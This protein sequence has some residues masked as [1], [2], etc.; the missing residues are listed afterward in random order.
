V[1]RIGMTLFDGVFACPHDCLWATRSGYATAPPGAPC[2]IGD[3]SPW[4]A[5]RRCISSTQKWWGARTVYC[6]NAGVT[7]D[8]PPMCLR[9]GDRPCRAASTPGLERRGFTPAQ[10]PQQ[11][12]ALIDLLYRSGL[13]LK[14]AMLNSSSA[15]RSRTPAFHANSSRSSAASSLAMA[16]TA[17]SPQSVPL[18][19]GVVA[20][21]DHAILMCRSHQF[22]LRRLRT[23][24]SSASPDLKCRRLGARV[25]GRRSLAVMGSCSRYCADL[26]RLWRLLARQAM[27]LTA[28]R[29]LHRHRCTGHQ[30]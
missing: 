17:A 5:Y 11:S 22:A 9:W 4:A 2:D 12:A 30:S 21:D 14:A 19:G 3:W 23:R 27:C 16:E 18:E 24:G 26:P 13:K 15:R 25:G 20:G 1:T 10:I 7:R 28:R 8:V 29:R 6:H